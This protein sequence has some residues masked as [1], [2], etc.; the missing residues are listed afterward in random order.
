MPSPITPPTTT[1]STKPVPS[2]FFRPGPVSIDVVWLPVTEIPEVTWKTQWEAHSARGDSTFSDGD[3]D[4]STLAAEPVNQTS[5][6][7]Q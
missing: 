7:E 2:V 6:W 1:A 4:G 5:R 3:V